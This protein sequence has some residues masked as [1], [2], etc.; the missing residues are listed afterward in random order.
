VIW[1][2]LGFTGVLGPIANVAHLTGLLWGA[3]YAVLD[4]A[5]FHRRKRRT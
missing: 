3:L 4:V 1:L 5:W 2:L